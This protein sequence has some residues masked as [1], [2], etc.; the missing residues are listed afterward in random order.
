MSIARMIGGLIFILCSG[1]SQAA[2]KCTKFPSQYLR[3]DVLIS[4]SEPVPFDTP[5]LKVAVT[6][7]KSC[8]YYNPYMGFDNEL[9]IEQAIKYKGSIYFITAS[10]DGVSDLLLLFQVN[11]KGNVIASYQSSTL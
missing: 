10:L 7:V 11:K 2:S 6:T 9:K 5:A 4:K 8:Y 1:C 3:N